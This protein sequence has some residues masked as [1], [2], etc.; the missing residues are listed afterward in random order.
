MI[1][2]VQNVRHLML[3]DD[4]VEAVRAKKLFIYAVARVEEAIELLTG[5]PAGQ[6]DQQGRFAEN[7]V[8]RKVAERLQAWHDAEKRDH[9]DKDD[10]KE[11]DE[12]GEEDR[13]PRHH[14]VPE[15]VP[16]PKHTRRRR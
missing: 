4:V 10:E 5:L 16:L 3:R 11:D 9:K 15:E 6:E 2:P 14:P 1:I 13:K 12:E 8:F 7:T